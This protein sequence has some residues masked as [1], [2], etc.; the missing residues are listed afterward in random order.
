MF[1]VRKLTAEKFATA[2][3]RDKTV[4]RFDRAKVKKLSLRGWKEKSGFE[5]ELVFE[6]KDGTWVVA[7]SPGALALMR[8]ASST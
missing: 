7:K 5:V 2:D 3:L 8:S 6:R 4:V 1:T